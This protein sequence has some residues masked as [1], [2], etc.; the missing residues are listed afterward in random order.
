LLQDYYEL[1]VILTR[2]RLFTQ[3]TKNLEKAKRLWDGEES[4]LAQVGTLPRLY[5][6][7]LLLTGPDSKHS[8]VGCT[9]RGPGAPRD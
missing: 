1:G 8:M 2:K 3:A 4:D 7:R 5:I 9:G 6:T